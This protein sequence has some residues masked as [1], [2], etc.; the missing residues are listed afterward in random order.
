MTTNPD[1]FKTTKPSGLNRVVAAMLASTPDR[2]AEQILLENDLS[3]RT[4]CI[5]DGKEI[6][7]MSFKGTGVCCEYCRKVRDGELVDERKLEE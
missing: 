1:G 2:P 4:T 6:T 3:V 5:V 7:V